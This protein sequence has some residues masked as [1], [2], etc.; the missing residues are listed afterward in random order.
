MRI[1]GVM[2]EHGMDESTVVLTSMRRAWGFGDAGHL[3]STSDF[4]CGHQKVG[5]VPLGSTLLLYLWEPLTV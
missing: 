5:A 2:S 1:L 3:G 4:L